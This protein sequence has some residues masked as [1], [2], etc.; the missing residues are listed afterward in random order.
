MSV[1]LTET[2]SNSMDLCN[3]C[4]Q[5]TCEAKDDQEYVVDTLFVTLML[6]G[7]PAC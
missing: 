6:T 7:R 1:R 2:R 3:L 5:A 4:V